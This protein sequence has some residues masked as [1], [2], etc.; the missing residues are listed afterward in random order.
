[1][2]KMRDTVFLFKPG[3]TDKGKHWF[4]P[5]SAQVVGFLNYFPATR[6]TLDI[7]EI[8]F[9]KP[10]KEVVELIGEEF[11]SL[12]V[13]ILGPGSSVPAALRDEVAMAKGYRVISD[14]KTILRYLAITRELPEPH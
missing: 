12:P 7:R 4:C 5:Y 8:D 13:L 9:A 3:F 14:T 10:R 2:S 6:S 11:Q 1:M